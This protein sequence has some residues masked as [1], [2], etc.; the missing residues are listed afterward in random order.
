MVVV[1]LLV[2]GARANMF[3]QSANKTKYKKNGVAT[4]GRIKKG[5]R[6]LLAH[7]SCT[8]VYK[9]WY[10]FRFASLMLLMF[11]KSII[12]HNGKYSNWTEALKPI[13]LYIVWT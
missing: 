3:P 12:T 4:V 11:V 6:L 8:V 13:H 5:T 2:V 9:L 7:I 1:F 10:F